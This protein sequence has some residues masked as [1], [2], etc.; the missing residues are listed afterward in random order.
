[1]ND[2]SDIPSLILAILRKNPRGLNI[3]EI[4]HRIDVN[5]TS[6]AKYLEV[7]TALD[8]VEVMSVGNAKIY[9]LSQR[10]PVTTLLK[11][12]SKFLVVLNRDFRIMQAN[13]AFAGYTGLP[14]DRIY[15]TAL[16]E[17][18]P[19]LMNRPDF[20]GLLEEALKGTEIQKEILIKDKPL[21]FYDVNIVPTE[22]PDHSP[23][24][25][26]ICYDIT[27][28]KQLESAVRQNE[29]MYRHLVENLNDI[30]F[31]V[32]LTGILTYISPQVNKYGYSQED[33]VGK[34]FNEIIYPEDIGL[35]LS[36]FLNI[37]DEGVYISGVLFRVPVPDGR[38][39]WLE[40]NGMLQ[41]D[42]S[43][44]FIG[45]NGVLRDISDRVSTERE[46]KELQK[47]YESL[48]N[49]FY[50][51]FTINPEDYRIESISKKLIERLGR[52]VTGECCYSALFNR[53]SA[54]PACSVGRAVNGE[55]VVQKVRGPGDSR[56]YYT[57]NTPVPRTDGS[58]AVNIIVNRLPEEIS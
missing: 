2:I 7:L 45:I 26:L 47:R 4:A 33:L 52:D 35:I 15:G 34:H 27:E 10:V 58:V 16:C 1:V 22:F 11:F 9:Y 42:G 38:L 46:L 32:D 21:V 14:Q 8:T 54:C 12:T 49:S 57:I 17:L 5:R 30:I 39:V 50:G 29:E 43:G 36:H 41:K 18:M 23:G 20:P 37:R 25:I 53:D 3:R 31:A 40:G 44:A 51:I 56:W 19:D 48:V 28:K 55:R 24:V 13:D 6:V